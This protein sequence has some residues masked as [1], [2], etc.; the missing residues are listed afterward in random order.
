MR[1]SCVTFP[2]TPAL[3]LRERETRSPVH[4][5]ILQRSRSAHPLL[6]EV[7]RWNLARELKQ[8][9]RSGHPL[10]GERAG[11]RGNCLFEMLLA[12]LST[13]SLS[14]RPAVIRQRM[15]CALL[16]R[17]PDRVADKL[18]LRPQLRIPEPHDLDSARF[19]PGVAFRVFCMLRRHAVHETIQLDIESGL[20]TEK[21]QKIRPK[22]MLSA[23]FVLA[24]APVSKPPP[25]KLL[26]PGIVLAQHARGARYFG[27]G[28]RDNR[29]RAPQIFAS[30]GNI[31]RSFP[32]HPGPLPQ[33]EG[34]PFGSATHIPRRATFPNP[35]ER[36]PS[37][38][39]EGWG[40]GERT[41]FNR[42]PQLT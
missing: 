29:S 34:D 26:R 5:Q 14:H 4:P 38:R 13:L 3:S 27:R 11:V 22:R 35:A 25:N 24:K 1:V 9:G 21:I 17:R 33:G 12:P 23:K 41:S 37:P 40:E 20:E 8:R 2:L 16:Q 19:Q 15:R 10:L 7:V 6:G 18:L 31:R 32:P 28:H 39:G 42:N 36:S 30:P